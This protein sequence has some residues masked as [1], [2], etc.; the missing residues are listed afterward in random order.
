MSN[1][2][3]HSDID[4]IRELRARYARYADTKQWTKFATIF[5]ADAVLRFFNPD[6]TLAN[7]V[8][9]AEFAETIGG[10]VGPGQPIH[11]F[12]THEIAFTSDTTA[13]G[14]WAMED[15]IFYDRD[16]HPDARFTTMHGYGHYHDAYRKVDG[17]W[18]ISG[19]DLTRLRV[20]I[21]E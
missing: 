19:A 10:R 1:P 18:R 11:H 8:T 14:L 15:L 6:G 16:E 7:E 3:T 2:T 9:G 13:T 20:D 21:V 17:V 5:T 4:Q 12:F